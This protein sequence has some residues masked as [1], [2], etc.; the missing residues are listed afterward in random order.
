LPNGALGRRQLLDEKL[1]LLWRVA[2][3]I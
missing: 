3:F 2:A 1:A